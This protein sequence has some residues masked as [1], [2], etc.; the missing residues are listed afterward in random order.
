[1][2]WGQRTCTVN[3][4]GSSS[5]APPD[6]VPSACADACLPIS[7]HACWCL[8]KPPL[9]PLLLLLPMQVLSTGRYTLTD[10]SC[11]ACC[12]TLGWQYLAAES[13]EQRYKVGAVLLQQAALEFTSPMQ[14]GREE[15]E[16]EGQEQEQSPTPPQLGQALG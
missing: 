15:G 2:V 6:P 16:Q 14:Q 5:H 1:M 4:A 10:V 11:R 8:L 13:Q 7:L 12:I 9:L 3:S